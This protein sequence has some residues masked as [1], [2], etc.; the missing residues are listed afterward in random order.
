MCVCVCVCVCVC[1]CVRVCV[2]ACACAC[3]CTRARVRACVRACVCVCVG[4]G[5]GRGGVVVCTLHNTNLLIL[6]ECGHL[7]IVA[8]CQVAAMNSIGRTLI[9]TTVTRCTIQYCLYTTP[10]VVLIVNDCD[11]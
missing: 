11:G 7:G 9:S 6:S 3:A 8:D 5:G 2:C 10:P 1:A 4:G